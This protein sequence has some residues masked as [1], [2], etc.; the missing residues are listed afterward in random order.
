MYHIDLLTLS[1]GIVSRT[2]VKCSWQITIKQKRNAWNVSFLNTIYKPDY[3]KQF[4]AAQ[5]KY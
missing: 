4:T 3:L 5:P 1:G 2:F